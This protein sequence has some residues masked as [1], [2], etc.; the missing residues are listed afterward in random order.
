MSVVFGSFFFKIFLLAIKYGIFNSSSFVHSFGQKKTLAI[1]LE[2]NTFF[3]FGIHSQIYTFGGGG[4][5]G[6]YEPKYETPSGALLWET[7]AFYDILV[8]RP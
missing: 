1:V 6:R 2:E 5:G 8:P 7:E 4:G 3:L